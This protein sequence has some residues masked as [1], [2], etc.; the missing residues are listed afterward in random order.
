MIDPT[1]RAGGANE[2]RPTTQSGDGGSNP[3]SALH[4]RE[5]Q[6]TEIQEVMERVHY[7]HSIFGVTSTHCYAVEAKGTV[8]GGA[9]YGKPAAYN[10]ARKYAKP[11]ETLLEL[12]R[13]VLE[14][15]CPRNS[16][17]RVLAVTFR[18]LRKCGVHV[19]LAYSD[20][21]VGHSGTIYRATGF[22]YNGKTASRTHWMWK[23]TKYPD[24]N[25]HQ[26]HFPYHKELRAAVA[27]GEATPVKI[28]GKHV[29]VKHL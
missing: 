17:S 18:L 27:T 3:T 2:A 8:C 9:I 6:L 11:G 25:L 26:V 12:R 22:S 16:E 28:P 15:W 13:F 4:V 7:T 19:V 10:V 1:L 20:P 29:F 24:R 23:G 14:D 5:C 21:A